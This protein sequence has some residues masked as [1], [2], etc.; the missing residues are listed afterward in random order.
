M[1]DFA[2]W[3]RREDYERIRSI[4]DDGPKMPATFDEWEQTAKSQL[5]RVAKTGIKIQPITLKPDEFL[6]YCKAQ[7]LRNRG[8]RER[9]MFAVARG[10]AKPLH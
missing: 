1:S 8:S 7:D 5:A 4:M 6:A 9:A 10:T 2:A 3:Y